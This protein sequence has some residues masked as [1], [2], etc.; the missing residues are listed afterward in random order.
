MKRLL[1]LVLTL[2]TI[3]MLMAQNDSAS[4]VRHQPGFYEN[5]IVKD[6]YPD[7]VFDEYPMVF[8]MDFTGKTFPTDMSKY[9]LIWHSLP[10]SQGNTGTCWCFAVTSFIE[11][12][13]YR[14]YQLKTDI[15]EMYTVYW[16]YVDRAKDYVKTKG[17]TYFAQGSESNAI[18]RVWSSYGVVPEQAYSGLPRYRKY[19]SHDQMESE[20]SKYLEGLKQSGNWD[21]VT[22]EK[23]IRAILNRHMGTPPEK[24]TYEGKEYTPKTWLNDYLKI[25]PKDY[26]SFMS[27]MEFSYN[28]KHELVEADNWFHSDDYYNVSLNDFITLVNDAVTAGY[29]VCLCGDVSEPGYNAIAEV[30]VVPDF[31]IPAAFINEASRQKRLSDGSTTDDHCIHIVGFQ[32][33]GDEYWYLIK[34]SGSGGFDGPNKGYR[35]YHE[36]YVKLKMMNIMIYKE[37]GRR[38]LD[39]IIK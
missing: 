26:F 7:V 16:E 24:F 18:K 29:S 4:F 32:K 33:V 21:I 36:D 28:E 12:E 34:D 9:T 20:M 15:S 23:E 22:A 31:D 27:T 13:V 1:L 11:S 14:R 8:R 35:F 17:E 5:E 30:A 37:A 10:K 19:H 3:T 6:V 38:V 2:V 25:D 39:R